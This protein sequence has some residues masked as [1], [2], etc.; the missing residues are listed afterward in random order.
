MAEVRPLGFGR[1]ALVCHR[2]DSKGRVFQTGPILCIPKY[3]SAIAESFEEVL[4][5]VLDAKQADA[6]ASCVN[7]G[8][9]CRETNSYKVRGVLPK[10]RAIQHTETLRRSYKAR[11]NS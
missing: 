8:F 5:Q 7:G 11:M 3:S 9:F 6:L 1:Q 10:S 4:R 2:L